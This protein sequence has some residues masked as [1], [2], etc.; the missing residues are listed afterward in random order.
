MSR[1]TLN[2][3]LALLA[4]CLPSSGQT[5]A[6]TKRTQDFSKEGVV[7]EQS[8]TKIVFQS[9]GSYTYEQRVRARIQSDSGVQ[10]YGILSFP[11]QAS[12]GMA[13]LQEVRVTKANGMVVTTP[14][15]S[16]QDVTSQVNRVA[17]RYSDL[18]EK[19]VAVK[20]L[21]A[22]DTLEYFVRWVMDKPLVPGQFWISCQFLKTSVVLDE[23]LEISLPRSRDVRVK[24][25]T[26]QPTK[27]E[28]GDRIIY[29]WRTSNLESQSIA[30]QVAN[31]SYE[32]PKGLLPPPDVMVSTFRSWEEIGRWYERLQQE[33]IKVTPEI[34]ASMRRS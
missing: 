34:R 21:E 7:I 22:G 9:D 4:F 28:D 30:K 11:Y 2:T 29:N 33:Q 27:R 26:V 8:G 10:Q 31:A 16:I 15:D 12:V 3:C 1:I 14:L 13:E 18:R 17:P 24:S 25:Q 32:A 19:H 6:T 23:Q 5:A 20:G